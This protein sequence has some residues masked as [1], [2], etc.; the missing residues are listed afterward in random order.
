MCQWSPWTGLPWWLEESS[1][2]TSM[3]TASTGCAC[4]FTSHFTHDSKHIYTRVHGLCSCVNL[5]NS[6][7]CVGDSC[8]Y[9]SYRRSYYTLLIMCVWLS[10]YYDF[11]YVR[12]FLT[13]DWLLHVACGCVCLCIHM[14]IGVTCVCVCVCVVL[15]RWHMID[16]LSDEG[17]VISITFWYRVRLPLT[18]LL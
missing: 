5:T 18:T 14:Y 10:A 16:T 13:F 3:N 6:S 4:H 7:K 8:S 11:Y 2:T 1:T 12:A 9:L 15:C 17:F